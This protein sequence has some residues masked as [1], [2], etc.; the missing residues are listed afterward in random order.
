MSRQMSSAYWGRGVTEPLQWKKS[1]ASGASGDCVE[2]AVAPVQKGDQEGVQD[3]VYV[4]DSKDPEG[5]VLQFSMREWNAFVEGVMRG[6]AS[7]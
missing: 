7:L 6:E 4:R 5:A 1:S 2:W 3:G